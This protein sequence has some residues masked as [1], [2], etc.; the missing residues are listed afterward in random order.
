VLSVQA[1]Q[2]STE[3]SF[4]R[5]ELLWLTPAETLVLGSG[6]E[7]DSAQGLGLVLR[8][9][10]VTRGSADGTSSRSERPWV[11]Y[12][13]CRNDLCASVTTRRTAAAR[14]DHDGR[15]TWGERIRRAARPI[16]LSVARAVRG[17]AEVQSP[18]SSA[19]EDGPSVN[20]P[21]AQVAPRS[22]P[23]PRS[24]RRAEEEHSAVPPWGLLPSEVPPRIELL[25]GNS[26]VR[27][28]RSSGRSA[29][30]ATLVAAFF[31]TVV[32]LQRQDEISLVWI[33]P[34]ILVIGGAM[35]VVLAHGTRA[36]IREENRAGYTVWRR[37]APKLPQVEEATGFVI[38][39]AGAPQLSRKQ[40]AAEVKRAREIA[41]FIARHPRTT[42]GSL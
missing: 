2:S 3:S 8:P 36:R 15:M 33:V 5:V 11:A 1:A 12:G 23:R 19:A 21:V 20:P 30:Q 6:S 29:A 14:T 39:P 7:I 13:C 32:L 26:S 42:G 41:R 27:I 37:K 18:Q 25:R 9:L 16:V 34:I 17:D 10:L 40:E 31:G 35:L 4:A 28:A 24:G 22:R 38:R